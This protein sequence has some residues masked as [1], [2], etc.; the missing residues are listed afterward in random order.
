MGA[1]SGYVSVGFVTMKNTITTTITASR[2]PMNRA[3]AA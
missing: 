1:R 2:I 3:F